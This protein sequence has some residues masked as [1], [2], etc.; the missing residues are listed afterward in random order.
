MLKVLHLTLHLHP[1][2]RERLIVGLSNQLNRI[3]VISSVACL[4]KSGELSEFLTKGTEVVEFHK[5]NS[6]DLSIIKPISNYIRDRGFNLIHCHNPGTLFYGVLAGKII[7]KTGIVN[8]E[9]GFVKKITARS[10]LKDQFLYAFTDRIIVVSDALKNDFIKN[11][12]VGL[13]KIHVIKNGSELV[14]PQES[15]SS[16]RERLNLDPN[17]YYIGIVARLTPIKNHKLLF[18]AFKFV[19]REIPNARLLVVGTGEIKK[20]LEN[21][22]QSLGLNG[23]VDFLGSR[24]DVSY[25]LN[26]IDLFVLSSDSEGLSMSILEAMGMGLPIIATNVGGNSE[27]IK[28]GITGILVPPR[29]HVSF[30]KAIVRVIKDRSSSTAL[31]DNARNRFF[32][33]FTMNKMTQNILAI[34]RQASA[35]S[36][37]N[38]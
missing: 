10:R 7:K 3:G 28:N 30:A 5:K 8:T 34:Y 14:I 16:S 9:H 15:R 20:E 33:E 25:I 4:K 19:V 13:G 23:Y 27:L 11:Y 21:Y 12:K 29:C 35:L 17:H 37:V 18:D 24:T 2:G 31:G 26:A 36:H 1:G 38:H 22:V 6:L 32:N